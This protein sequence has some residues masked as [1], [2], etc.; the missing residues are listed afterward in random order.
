MLT[1]LGPYLD[2][3]YPNR[4]ATDTWEIEFLWT[5]NEQQGRYSIDGKCLAWVYPTR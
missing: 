1:M 4:I 2:L 3:G 5:T